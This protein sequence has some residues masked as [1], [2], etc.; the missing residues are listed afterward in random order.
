M[1]E[2]ISLAFAIPLAYICLGVA[3]LSAVL[4]PVIF[5]FQDLKKARTALIGVGFMGAV[6]LVCYF[7]ADRVDF[8]I[9]E[10]HVAA[11]QMQF[12]EAGIFMFYALLMISILA[13]ASSALTRFLK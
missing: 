8:S 5:M 7:M 9:G 4:F 3:A 13:I 12:V 2:S 6:Y 1:L 11:S 10:K